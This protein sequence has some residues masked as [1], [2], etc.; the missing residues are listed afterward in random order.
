M[1]H[2]NE[3]LVKKETEASDIAKKIL[4]IAGTLLITGLC[5]YSV[6]VFG[7][8]PLIV[9]VFGVFYLSWYLM[10]STSVEYEYIVTNNDMDIDK[11]VGQRKRKRLIT[12]KLNTVTEWGKYTEGKNRGADAT[13]MASDATGIG[14]WYLLA[15]HDKFG[16]VMV[17]FTPTKETAVNINHGVPYAQRKKDLFFDGQEENEE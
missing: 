5:V 3:Q 11:I 7:F 6:F 15:K 12:V 17:I 9:L 4:I 14:A 1:D 8:L 10:T 13:V 2:Y 16:N